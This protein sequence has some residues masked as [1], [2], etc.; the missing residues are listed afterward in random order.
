M[1]VPDSPD[2]SIFL[3]FDP[4]VLTQGLRV[5]RLLT[6]ERWRNVIRAF[7]PGTRDG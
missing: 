5:C 6:T 2:L 7:R 3:S 4:E 1:S